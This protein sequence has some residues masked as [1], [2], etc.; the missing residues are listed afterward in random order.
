MLANRKKRIKSIDMLRGLVMVIMALDHVRDYFHADAYFFDPSDMAQTNVPLFWTRFVTHFCAPVFVFLAGTSAF[1]V[2]QRRDKKSLSIWLLKRGLWLVIAELTIIKL[3]W[4]FK[5]DY[6]TILLQVIWVLGISMI[7]LAG[8]IHLPKKFMIGLALLAVFGHNLLDPIAPTDTVASGFWTFL[9]VFNIVNMGSFQVF[10]GYPMIPWIFVMP[11]GFYFGELYKPSYDPKLRI[12]RLFQLGLGLTLLF[13]VLRSINIY[14]D[15]YTWTEQ[16]SFG[17]TIASYFNITKYPPS[18]LYLLI[19]LGPSILFLAFVENIQNQWTEKLVVI[20]R[21]PMFFY[22]VH[23]YVIHL[24][25]V[26]AAM[27]TG[28]DFSDMVIDIWVTLQPQLQGYGFDLWVVYLVWIVLTIALYPVCSWY[29]NYK[30]NHREKWWL[31]YL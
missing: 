3:A 17:M 5:L 6:S 7:F 20:G 24:L 11:L 22:I 13:F 23:I 21:V 19:T 1:F 18:L 10:V 8:F 12:K 28:F 15:P 25:A 26:V 30:T 4:M 27:S 2:G 29:N 14:G 9:H 16:E 31:S